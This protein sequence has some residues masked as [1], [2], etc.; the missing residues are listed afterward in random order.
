M[1][2]G[3][4]SLTA[5][6][7][8][9]AGAGELSSERSPENIRSVGWAGVALGGSALLGGLFGYFSEPA[10]PRARAGITV[11]PVGAFGRF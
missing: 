9:I 4:A 2:A 8:L 11:T 5:G 1:G 6:L 7:L 10:K 3:A